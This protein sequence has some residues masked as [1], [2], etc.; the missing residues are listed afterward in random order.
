MISHSFLART[1]LFGH[2]AASLPAAQDI[3]PEEVVVNLF[4]DYEDFW[5]HLWERNRNFPD[6]SLHA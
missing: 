4:M 5:E 2:Y 1:G 6:F 3:N